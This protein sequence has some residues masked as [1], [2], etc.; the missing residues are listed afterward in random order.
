MKENQE[1]HKDSSR[2]TYYTMLTVD[3]HLQDS[4]TL[5]D[6]TVTSREEGELAQL[7]NCAEQPAADLKL[8]WTTQT[9][10]TAPAPL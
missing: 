9:N 10:I 4:L 2:T 6:K 1:A 5:F 7:S 8:N 3:E